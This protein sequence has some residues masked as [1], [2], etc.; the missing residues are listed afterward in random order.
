MRSPKKKKCPFCGRLF[1]PDPRVGD[2]QKACSDVEE[3]YASQRLEVSLCRVKGG[4][5][6]SLIA[7]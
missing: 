6:N 4:E 7:S 5:Q 1:L 3:L 2:R